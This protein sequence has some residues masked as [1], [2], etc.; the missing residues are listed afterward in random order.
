MVKYLYYYYIW[1]EQTKLE[2]YKLW[3]TGM[4]IFRYFIAQANLQN[5]LPSHR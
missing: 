2:I 4:N 3:Q 5:N 1:F